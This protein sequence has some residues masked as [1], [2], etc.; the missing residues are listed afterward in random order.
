M[1]VAFAKQ[2]LKSRYDKENGPLEPLGVRQ[3]ASLKDTG[4][5]DSQWAVPFVCPNPAEGDARK[6]V[7]DAVAALGKAGLQMPPLE[8]AAIGAEWVAVKCTP[9]SNSGQEPKQQ[10]QA[11]TSEARNKGTIIYLHGGAFL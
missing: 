7:L 4:P 1:A 5:P 2:A 6:S 8:S 9:G 10:L 11:L 3:K